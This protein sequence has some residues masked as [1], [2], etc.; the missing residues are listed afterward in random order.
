[1]TKTSGA[2]RQAEAQ[3]HPEAVSPFVAGTDGYKFYRIPSLL[4]TKKGTLLGFC[5]GRSGGD[6]SD[7]NLLVKRS[8]D[9]GKTWDTQRLRKIDIT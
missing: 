2:D 3:H 4:L 5:E 7:V 6:C 9:G 8:E 1:M